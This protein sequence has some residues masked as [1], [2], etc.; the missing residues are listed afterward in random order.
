MVGLNF[1]VHRTSTA[2]NE[3]QKSV[4]SNERFSVSVKGCGGCFWEYLDQCCAA[5]HLLSG[6]GLEEGC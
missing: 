5:L 1:Y 2:T 3:K 4:C 6:M